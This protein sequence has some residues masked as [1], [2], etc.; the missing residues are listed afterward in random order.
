MHLAFQRWSLTFCTLA[1][2]PVHSFSGVEFA[3]LLLG[4]SRAGSVFSPSLVDVTTLGSL[5]SARSMARL[6]LLLP[7]LEHQHIGF[8]L[9]TQ[10]HTCFELIVPSL[11]WQLW[12]TAVGAG[13]CALR[14]FAFH[15]KLCSL[16]P[17]P[18]NPRLPSLG[19]QRVVT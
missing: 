14:T 10:S 9:F 4:L 8:S 12:F 1:L 19:L 16:W 13:L 11:E 7:T 18:I 17:V 5:P 6:E 15:P 2:L 3:M